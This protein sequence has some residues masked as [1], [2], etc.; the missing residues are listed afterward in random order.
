[1]EARKYCL[2]ARIDMA[3]LNGTLRDPVLYRF[4]RFLLS[5]SRWFSS[6][7]NVFISFFIFY[8]TCIFFIFLL[9]TYL[10]MTHKSVLTCSSGDFL[11]NYLWQNNYYIFICLSIHDIFSFS[12]KKYI[13]INQQINKWINKLP[14]LFLSSTF[15]E[16]LFPS[17]I[18]LCHF[19][20]I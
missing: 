2:R 15:P 1:M 18:F 16:W 5:L 14:Q 17:V 11:W 6:S 20:Q 10:W 12:I 3:S 4:V 13:Y 7:V 19:T 8:F 9:W